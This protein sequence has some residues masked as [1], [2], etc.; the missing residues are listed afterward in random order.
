[1]SRLM[2]NLLL[3]RGQDSELRLLNNH[4][5]SLGNRMGEPDI[6]TDNR[7]G[8]DH[9]VSPQDGGSGIDNHVVLNGG[10]TLV[11]TLEGTVGL[12]HETM[13]SE[14]HPLVD[15]NIVT[16]RCRLS[17]D[18]T[19]AVVDKEVL[20]D[21]CPRMNVDSGLTVRIFCHHSGE[22]RDGPDEELMGDPVGGNGHNSRVAENDLI[23]VLCSRIPHIGGVYVACEDLAQAGY[24]LEK[25]NR[26]SLAPVKA[27]GAD[28]LG[29]MTLVP[30]SSRY[31]MRQFLKNDVDLAP[32]VIG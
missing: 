1:M 20:S 2:V 28:D 18:N 29:P 11:A 4:L 13:G 8:T 31:L 5:A 19:G 17:N 27:M 25:V 30:D 6:S 32:Q 23:Q 7:S 21:G 9:G 15:S 14:G 12:L 24:L 3:L 10:M 22:N 26:L 16:D